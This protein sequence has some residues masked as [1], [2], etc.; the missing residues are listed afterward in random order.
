MKLQITFKI[1]QTPNKFGEINANKIAAKLR[2]LANEI[3]FEGGY[4]GNGNTIL[5]SHGKN[6]GSWEIDPQ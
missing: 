5:N 1:E 6:I 2:N 3:Q 4:P